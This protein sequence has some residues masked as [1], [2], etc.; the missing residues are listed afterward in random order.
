M[1]D[2]IYSE[3]MNWYPIE[4]PQGEYTT[5]PTCSMW[6][7]FENNNIYLCKKCNL[8]FGIGCTLEE[9]GC[10][11]SSY[12]PIIYINYTNSCFKIANSCYFK[13]TKEEQKE[14]IKTCLCLEYNCD[15]PESYKAFY[16]KNKYPQYYECYC[17]K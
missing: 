8:I 16:P 11:S 12:Y 14:Y 5:C 7:T 1:N 9:K 2:E 10:V 6:I 13:L 15:R 4:T 3:Y 17:K